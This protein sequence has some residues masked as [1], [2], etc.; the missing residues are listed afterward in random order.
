MIKIN[1]YSHEEFEKL[2]ELD[3]DDDEEPWD[4]ET[5]K[6]WDEKMNSVKPPKQKEKAE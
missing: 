5:Q 2:F 6:D 3:E 1:P 4:E